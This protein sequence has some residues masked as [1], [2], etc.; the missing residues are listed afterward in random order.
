MSL[1]IRRLSNMISKE[2]IVCKG[3]GKRPSE[4]AEY[5]NLG[6]LYCCSPADAVI[7]NEGTYN[8]KTG[9]FYCTSCYIKAGMPLGKA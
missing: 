8:P 5:V 9:Q 2:Q 4:I 3:C 6:E 7:D 1:K